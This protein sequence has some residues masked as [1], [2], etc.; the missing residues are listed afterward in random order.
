MLIEE[1]YIP[2]INQNVTF[3]IGKNAQDNFDVIDKGVENDLWFHLDNYSSCHVV[4]VINNLKINKKELN[5]IIKQGAVIC[6]KHSKYKSEKNI[7]IVYTTINNITKTEIIGQ[8]ILK[9]KK[10]VII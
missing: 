4:G 8:V 1:I 9:N 10:T 3:Y 6:K 7:S 5:A 2:K